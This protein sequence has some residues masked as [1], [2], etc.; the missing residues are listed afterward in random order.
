VYFN[1]LG[2]VSVDPV[3]DGGFAIL[4]TPVGIQEVI[5]ENHE[6]EKISSQVFYAK[7]SMTY[8]AHFAD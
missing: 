5:V 1:S 2:E 3:E 8:L 4:N 6:N 7:D